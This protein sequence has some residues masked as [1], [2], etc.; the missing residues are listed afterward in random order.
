MTRSQ[1]SRSRDPE[2]VSIHWH[3]PR[4]GLPPQ[5][6]RFHQDGDKATLRL[7]EKGGKRRTIGIHF[8]VAE[9]ITEYINHAQLAGGV[10][11]RPHRYSKREELFDRVIDETTMWRIIDSYLKRLPGAVHE[12]TGPDGG[13]RA[14]CIYTPHSLRSTTA[15][16]LLDAGVDITRVQQ[17]LGHRHLMT[18]QIYDKRRRSTSE[19]ASHEVPI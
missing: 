1:L 8:A 2:D 5:G 9:A 7:Q 16:L 13:T 15:T 10:L 11:F 17:L 14:E 19:S 12:V 3:S 4:N 18:T 6:E